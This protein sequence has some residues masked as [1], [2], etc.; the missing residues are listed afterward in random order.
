VAGVLA[1]EVAAGAAGARTSCAAAAQPLGAAP[2]ASSGTSGTSSTSAGS[3][4]GHGQEPGAD[5]A[6]ARTSRR[7]SAL[8]HP[9]SRLLLPPYAP[10]VG[11]LRQVVV[12]VPRTAPGVAFVHEPVM[13]KCLE[14]LLYIWGVRHPAS[15]YV[16][17]GRRGRRAP[18][19]LPCAALGSARRCCRDDARAELLRPGARCS[20][21][22]AAALMDGRPPRQ[23]GRPL[24]P[25]PNLTHHP[26]PHP[27]HHPTTTRTPHTCRA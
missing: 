7:R 9:L 4:R 22:G 5:P 11:A 3:R 26:P 6:Q 25:C 1:G 12:D 20:G 15:G 16:Q 2:R 21:E 10:Q 14:R 18:G 27:P 17:V 13:Q 8:E 19:P 24:T 23:P